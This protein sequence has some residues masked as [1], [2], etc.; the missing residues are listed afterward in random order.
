MARTQSTAYSREAW[1]AVTSDSDAQPDRHPVLATLYAEHRYMATLM[2]LLTEQLTA[3]EHDEPVDAHVLYELMQYMSSFPDQYHHPRE[4]MVYQRAAQL[5]PGL[6]DSVDTLERDH[7]YL[8]KVGS[9]T[10]AAIQNWRSGTKPAKD[11][12]A[13]GHEYVAALYRHMSGEEKIIFPHIERLL[14]DADWAELESED[15]LAPVADPVFGTRVAR[16]YRKLARSAR[17]A[18]REGAED[19]AVGEWIGVEAM[20]EGLE[21]INI[22]L[23]SGKAA[24]R[25]HFEEALAENISIV[26]EAREQGGLVL[27][28]LRC[29]MANTGHYFGFLRDCGQLLRDTGDDLVEVNRGMRQRLQFG[30]REGAGRKGDQTLH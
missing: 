20:L 13:H 9:D 26:E 15:L 24:A 8:A 21:V 22:A 28:P 1:E 10:L 16:E 4:D 25:D 30:R 19:V 29:A 6:A 14:S 12:V 11:I 27:V 23:D 5:D 3:L 7:D 2:K 18:L 17:R